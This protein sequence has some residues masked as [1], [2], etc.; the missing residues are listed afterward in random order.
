MHQNNSCGI[1]TQCESKPKPQGQVPKAASL[2]PLL[3][4][5]TDNQLIKT[6]D[7]LR[8][9]GVAVA[10]ADDTY[11]KRKSTF[12]GKGCTL[13]CKD[14]NDTVVRPLQHCGLSCPVCVTLH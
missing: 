8:H 3:K 9:G 7:Q 13:Q 12:N 4:A 2:K 10:G 11:S 6:D 1:E 5:K 14:R